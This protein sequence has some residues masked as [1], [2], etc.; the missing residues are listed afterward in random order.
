MRCIVELAGH[1]DDRMSDG[2]VPLELSLQLRAM[3]FIVVKLRLVGPLERALVSVAALP[4]FQH[5]Q[6]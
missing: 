4:A 6:C 5:V 1:H 3:V 2:D